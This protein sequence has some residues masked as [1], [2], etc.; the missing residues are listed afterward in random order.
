[1][2]EAPNHI[3]ALAPFQNARQPWKLF[4]HFEGQL[5]V[6]QGGVTDMVGCEDASGYALQDQEAT[7]AEEF[8]RANEENYLF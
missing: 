2:A 1:M 5:G 4:L 7:H 3:P 6:H 8:A